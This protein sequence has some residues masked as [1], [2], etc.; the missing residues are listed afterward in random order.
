MELQISVA[1]IDPLHHHDFPATGDSTVTQ[2]LRR[3]A[4]ACVEP[5]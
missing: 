5:V 2:K 4:L 3:V 1:L